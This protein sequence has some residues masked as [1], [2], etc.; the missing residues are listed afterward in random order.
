M[1][2]TTIKDIGI[3]LTKQEQCDTVSLANKGN[4]KAIEQLIRTNLR[5]IIK[6]ANKFQNCSL[7]LEDLV[8]EGK[9]GILDAIKRFNA[10][11]DVKFSTFATF[12]VYNRIS[13]YVRRNSKLIRCP[14]YL[15]AISSKVSDYQSKYYQKYNKYPSNNEIQTNFKL[16]NKK[17][18]RVMSVFTNV[19]S[20]DAIRNDD[21]FEGNLYNLIRNED[22]ENSIVNAFSI[23]NEEERELLEENSGVWEKVS[24]KDLAKKYGKTYKEVRGIVDGAKRKLNK[25]LNRK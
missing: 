4:E 22:S 2:H 14:N 3:K 15:I 18:N 23:L 9:I 11:K 25:E 7:D 1:N 5:L 21:D 17:L 20:L 13:A 12:H 10:K 8:S 19:E 16:S 6:V 24:F